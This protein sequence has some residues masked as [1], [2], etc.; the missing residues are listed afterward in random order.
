MAQNH[1]RNSRFWVDKG[2]ALGVVL[3]SRGGGHTRGAVLSS[4]LAALPKEICLEYYGVESVGKPQDY[5]HKAEV[6]TLFEKIEAIADSLGLCTFST[7]IW[8]PAPHAIFLGDLIDLLSA[9]IDFRGNGQELLGIGER[10]V[11][12]EKGF[13]ILHKG[14]SRRDDYPPARFVDESVSGG[15][16]LEGECLVLEKWDRML[17]KYY[18]LHGWDLQTSWPTRKRLLELGL[19]DVIDRLEREGKD[20]SG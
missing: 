13:N 9:S 4:R 19:T 2:W 17:D 15:G 18:Q 3:S 20:L 16:S 7:I 8:A 5:E 6:V 1:F 10:I 12:L 14:W 11:N